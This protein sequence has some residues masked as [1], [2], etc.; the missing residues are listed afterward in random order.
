MIK[1]TLTKS[2]AAERFRRSFAAECEVA[3]SRRRFVQ[4]LGAGLLITVTDGVS[5]GQ[6]R[7]RDGRSIAVAAR[8]HLNTDGTFTVM[9][10]DKTFQ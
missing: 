10:L 6:R 3:L 9:T 2:I 7:S 1:D 4:L 5:V 8:L